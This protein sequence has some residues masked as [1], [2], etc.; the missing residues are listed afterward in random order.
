M[1]CNILSQALIRLQFIDCLFNSLAQT[2]N[3]P[4]EKLKIE[5]L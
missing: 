1:Y 4:Q 3:Q 2:K 5:I